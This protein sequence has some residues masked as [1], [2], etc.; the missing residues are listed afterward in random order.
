MLYFP[1]GS[2]FATGRVSYLDADPH[3]Q[4]R[5]SAIYLPVVLPFA[6][7][8]SVYALLDTGSPFCVF[9]S[10]LMAAAGIDFDAGE[11]V[12]LSTRVE[13]IDGRLQRLALLIA[14]EA[15]EALSV[16]ASVF[17]T[18]DWRHGHF[19]GYGGFLE[20]LRV[21]VDPLTNTCYFGPG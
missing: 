17:V 21:A 20:R 18:R 8:I 2:P 14:A 12:A 3:G 10:A 1:D 5:Q 15:G 11:P 13:R 9:D 19:L 6:Q 7:D 4:H 16:D